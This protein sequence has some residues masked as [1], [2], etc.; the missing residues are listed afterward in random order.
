MNNNIKTVIL[1]G[2]VLFVILYLYNVM[3]NGIKLVEME[4]MHNLAPHPNTYPPNFYLR[5][6]RYMATLCP[7]CQMDACKCNDMI[8]DKPCTFCQKANC[9]CTNEF[10]NNCRS[11]KCQCKNKDNNCILGPNQTCKEQA[12]WAVNQYTGSG[13]TINGTCGDNL[14]HY[15]SPRMVLM[16]NC[17]RCHEHGSDKVYVTPS[18]VV[19]PLTKLHD[20]K[21]KDTHKMSS[22]EFLI[23][24]DPVCM[25]QPMSNGIVPIKPDCV[26]ARVHDSSKCSC[27]GFG[28]VYNFHQPQ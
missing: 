13:T 1:V 3:N 26:T 11:M 12:N 24:Q 27:D 25:S 28:K 4:G 5:K 9:S 10:C 8:K 20:T 21:I 18:G 15:M 2:I 14:W 16:D 6:N 22:D 17:M 19:S 7:G 23:P